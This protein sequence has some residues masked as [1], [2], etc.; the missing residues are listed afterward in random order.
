MGLYHDRP[1]AGALWRC[2][3]LRRRFF[4][5]AA[6]GP[7]FARLM[8]GSSQASFLGGSTVCG[9]C[10]AAAS[11]FSCCLWP[12]KW[13]AQSGTLGYS[14]TLGSR[15]GTLGAFSPAPGVSSQGGRSIDKVEHSGW[16]RPVAKQ[17]HG[18][19]NRSQKSEILAQKEAGVARISA[20][21]LWLRCAE[22]SRPVARGHHQQGKTRRDQCRAEGQDPACMPTDPSR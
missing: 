13:A 16:Y 2:A 11:C 7:S 8:Y 6:L 20:W 9:S 5:M 4:A 19:K 15:E 12:R 18:G 1:P 3:Y 21:H 17:R 10:A 14:L 22:V